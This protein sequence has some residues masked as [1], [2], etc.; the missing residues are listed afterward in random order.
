MARTELCF[1]NW[2]LWGTATAAH[3]VEGNN[4]HNDWWAWEQA[5]GRIR[6]GDRSGSACDWWNRAE[7]DFDLARDLGQNSHRLSLEWSRLEP[8]PGEW[9]GAACARYRQMLAGLRER[10]IE[11]MVTLYHFTLP[12]WLAEMGGWTH[13]HA[14]RYFSRYVERVVEELGDLITLWCTVNEPAGYAFWSYLDGKWPPGQQ[15]LPQALR[16]LRTLLLAHGEAYR[17]IHAMRGDAQVGLAKIVPLFEPARP[18]SILDRQL[19]SLVDRTFNAL[20]LNAVMSGRFRP[21]L[22][23]GVVSRL[24]DTVDF[25]GVNYYTRFLIGWNREY[26]A[27][28]LTPRL[29]AGVETSDLNYGEI[30]P[31]GLYRVLKRVARYGKPIYIT[32]N[33]LPD[34][35]D[36]VRPRFLLTHLAQVWRAMQEG[37]LVR[38][39][40]HWTLVDNFEW[41]EGYAMRF[42]LIEVDFAT[43]ERR[44]RES[45]RLYG[46]IAQANAITPELVEQYA[47]EAMPAIFGP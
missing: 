3:Q 37:V 16:V 38:G 9:N 36:D 31:P 25:I 43:Q 7:A 42:G 15:N 12:L 32:E 34:H 29:K 13:P 14:L 11:P 40:Y 24:I 44:I 1:P 23:F 46:Q 26:P 5:G 17:I 30:Y 19:T 35:D 6:G 21:P 33:G 39:Y 28:S 8:R 18:E 41:A 4:V 2:F 45:A 20:P 22:G 10:G 27:A 47:P